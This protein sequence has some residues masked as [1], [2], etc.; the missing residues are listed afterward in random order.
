LRFLYIFK[1]RCI[2]YRLSEL[3]YG[4]QDAKTRISKY[5]PPPPEHIED[6]KTKLRTLT[7]EPDQQIEAEILDSPT[8]TPGS[9]ALDETTRSKFKKTIA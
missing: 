2:N 8:Q 1:E 7:I 5:V 9:F 6:M 4:K 3:V